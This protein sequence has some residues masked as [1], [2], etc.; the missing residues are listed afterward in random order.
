VKEEQ[1]DTP[2]VRAGKRAINAE[3]ERFK[4]IQTRIMAG[5][6]R[7]GSEYNQLTDCLFG[8]YAAAALVWDDPAQL[9]PYAEAVV[10]ALLAAEEF[11]AP[12]LAQGVE[13]LQLG[14]QLA[15]ARHRAEVVVLKL[16]EQAKKK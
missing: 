13:E 2:A 4:L 3:A 1:A 8:Q 10:L 7:G 5:S 16:R 15:A 9:L 14:P 11:N 12:R 6:L